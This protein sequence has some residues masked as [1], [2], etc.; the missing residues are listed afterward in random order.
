MKKIILLYSVLVLFSSCKKEVS[1]EQ[2]EI[3]PI[4]KKCTACLVVTEVKCSTPERNH[5]QNDSVVFC[6]ENVLELYLSQPSVQIQYGADGY[7][8]QTTTHYSCQ[9]N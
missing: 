2:T 8:K 7:W 9:E 3:K 4:Q 1:N 5:T 6:D